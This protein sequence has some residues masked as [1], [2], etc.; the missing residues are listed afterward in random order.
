MT[1]LL[2]DE[3]EKGDAIE[4]EQQI[5]SRDLKR[6]QTITAIG[7]HLVTVVNDEREK[8]AD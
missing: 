5:D 1:D 6:Q 8:S 2:A 3:V 7:T 4:K